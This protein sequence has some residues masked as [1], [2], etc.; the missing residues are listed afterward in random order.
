MSVIE[1][2]AELLSK[3]SPAE[4]AWLYRKITGMGAGT[5]PGIEKT[6]GICGGSAVIIRT[7]VPVWSLVAYKNLGLSDEV[8]LE[9]YP[10]LRQ[11]DLANAWNYYLANPEEIDLEIRENDEA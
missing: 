5:F 1:R 4:K 11:Q 9:N 6:P 7:R 10:T 8:L 2:A 3:M